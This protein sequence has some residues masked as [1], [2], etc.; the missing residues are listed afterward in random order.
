MDVEFCIHHVAAKLQYPTNWLI[1]VYLQTFE[2]TLSN[3]I[4]ANL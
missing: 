4:Q 1:I 3:A 2:D